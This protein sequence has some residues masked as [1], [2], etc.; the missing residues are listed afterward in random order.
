MRLGGL[1]GYWCFCEVLGLLVLLGGFGASLLRG[2][3]GVGMVALLWLVVALLLV[4][5]GKMV[6]S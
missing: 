6:V 1:W 5:L 2:F 3:V 4:V